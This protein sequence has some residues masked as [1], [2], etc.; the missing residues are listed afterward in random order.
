MHAHE[1]VHV[2]M[3]L[4]RPRFDVRCLPHP[5][6]T[7]F[8]WD[9]VYFIYHWTRRPPIAQAGWPLAHEITSFW[10]SVLCVQART[11]RLASLPHRDLYS[12]PH[13][14]TVLM[15]SSPEPS[16]RFYSCQQLSLK[17]PEMWRR[18]TKEEPVWSHP[19]GWTKT[20][21]HVVTCRHLRCYINPVRPSPQVKLNPSYRKF[22]VRQ[23]EVIKTHFKSMHFIYHYCICAVCT[24]VCMHV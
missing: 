7:L 23:C 6:S 18:L 19:K 3:P 14:C 1:K 9:R 13:A 4:E 11:T 5:V 8:F 15:K 21:L 2:C 22:M 17:H 12:G 20:Q 16:S 24:C 10:F